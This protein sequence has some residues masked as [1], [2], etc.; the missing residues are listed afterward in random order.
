MDSINII[1]P[2]AFI[3]FI[4]VITIGYILVEI[5]WWDN[6]YFRKS[7]NRY[8]GSNIMDRLIHYVSIWILF[9]FATI[10]CISFAGKTEI[11]ER[12]MLIGYNF[13]QSI[14]F[15]DGATHFEALLNVQLI[16]SSLI[17]FT[18]IIILFI[19][20]WIW[21]GLSRLVSLI[22][23]KIARNKKAIKNLSVH[24]KSPKILEGKNKN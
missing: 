19:A 10:I 1:Q 13:S 16:V 11:I 5:V 4:L 22:Y 12:A 7:L 8:T 23:N 15:T 2:S 14:H 21:V 17:Y 6:Y 18:F 20:V 3:F 9:H 24:T